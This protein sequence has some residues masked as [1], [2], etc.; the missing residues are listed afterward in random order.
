[1]SG[2]A[3][4]FEYWSLAKNKDRGFGYVAVPTSTKPSDNKQNSEDFVDFAKA[5]AEEALLRWI[6]GSEAF[7]AKLHPEFANYGDYDQLMRL[8]EWNGRQ[9]IV[10]DEA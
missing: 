7:T 8:Q 4:R 1:V 5:Q 9:R 2:Q 6:L 3:G 10:E